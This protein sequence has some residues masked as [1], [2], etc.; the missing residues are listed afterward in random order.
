MTLIVAL[1]P[2]PGIGDPLEWGARII[3][4]TGAAASGFKVG[5]PLLLKAGPSGLK[6]LA[7]LMPP[8]SLKVADLKLAD[9]GPVMSSAAEVLASAGY[10]TVIAHGFV[11]AEGGLD[12]LA[13]TCRSLGLKLVVLV[14]MSHPAAS[15]IM[16]PLL[17]TLLVEAI[18][19]DAWG[20]VAPATRPEI[21]AR[22]RRRLGSGYTILSP[23]VGVQGAEPGV[24]L[25]AGA[26]Y[27][28]VGRRI[29]RSPNPREEAFLVLERQREAVSRCK[30]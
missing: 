16:D 18:R 30:A 22:A 26:D 1:D 27:E 12:E 24:A 15:R 25:C 5:L 14:S 3:G 13:D 7:S 29:T 10:D 20:V 21:V 2:P 9:I 11:G 17:D 6:R 19:V 4:E 8:E 28:I 23:G